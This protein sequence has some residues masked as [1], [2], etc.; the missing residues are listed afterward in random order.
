MAASAFANSQKN[1]CPEPKGIQDL[2]A[3]QNKI[4]LNQGSTA[5]IADYIEALI[6]TARVACTRSGASA[7]PAYPAE[8]DLRCFLVF[9]N[10][11][12]VSVNL[13]EG[14]NNNHIEISER[15]PSSD[16]DEEGVLLAH[17][18]MTKAITYAQALQSPSIN[19]NDRGLKCGF[20]H[21]TIVNEPIVRD[22]IEAWVL[23]PIKLNST[24]RRTIPKNG[25]VPPEQLDQ[26]LGELWKEHACL[27]TKMSE[28]CRRLFFFKSNPNK[29]P[30]DN[31]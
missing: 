9:Q 1:I 5:T 13:V 12:T 17:F 16:P 6:A 21:D 11:S 4:I 27:Q 31:P 26:V 25:Q 28:T 7:Q 20:C 29:V 23:T 24:V 15:V 14:L 2:V 30:L 3:C 22:G 19:L 10:G 18:Y 8:G